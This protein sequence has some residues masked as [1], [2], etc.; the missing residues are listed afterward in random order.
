MA[1]SDQLTSSLETVIILKNYN[2][3]I[4]DEIKPLLGNRLA[5]IGGGVG[6]FTEYLLAEHLSHNPASHL[7]VFEPAAHLYQKM[8]E[9]LTGSYA[10]LIQAG[11]LILTQDYFQ[12]S[13]GNYDTVILINVLEHIQDDVA[14]LR[15]VHASIANKGVLIVFVPALD[16]LYSSFDKA[17]GHHRRYQQ[18][19]L[20]KL[21]VTAGFEVV[22][23][24]YM[25]CLG[26]LPWYF[27]NVV[28]RSQ[29]INPW[30]AQLYDK[31]FVPM[32]RR[33]ESLHLPFAGKNLLI[34][35]RKHTT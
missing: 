5:E 13:Q 3:W 33:I 35:G 17:V 7:E 20:E 18:P 31:V 23:S 12:P 15:T 1:N 16:L 9:R 2:Q 29:S 10:G 11:R 19:A 28:C 25:D 24:K 32:T 4:I 34:I 14:L 27:L 6:T 30:L 21:F 8:H 22:K 26:I